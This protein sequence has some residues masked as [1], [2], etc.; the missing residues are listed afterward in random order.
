MGK[1]WEEELARREAALA[2]KENEVKK[3]EDEL[4]NERQKSKADS[5]ETIESLEV[6]LQKLKKRERELSQQEEEEM[7]KQREKLQEIQAMKAAIVRERVKIERIQDQIDSEDVP[8]HDS[9]Y[10]SRETT[11]SPPPPQPSPRR[12]KKYDDEPPREPRRNPRH[13]EVGR[14]RAPDLSNVKSKTV[15]KNHNYRR[16]QPNKVKVFDDK[17]YR[18]GC[19]TGGY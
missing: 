4:L 11:A 1:K 8:T 5:I 9:A 10:A 16:P 14:A 13:P 15:T 12:K 17:G 18:K 6:R 7:A 19:R 3:K 2:E